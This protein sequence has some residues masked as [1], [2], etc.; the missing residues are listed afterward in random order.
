MMI[1]VFLKKWWMVLFLDMINTTIIPLSLNP[2]IILILYDLFLFLFMT[3]L[4][5]LILINYYRSFNISLLI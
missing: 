4:L 3:L 1:L 5:I 2:N